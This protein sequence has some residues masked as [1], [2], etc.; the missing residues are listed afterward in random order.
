[1]GALGDEVVDAAPALGVA[2]VPV[3][4]RAVLDG[5]VVQRH[6]LDHR[7]VQLVLVAHRRGAALQV[8]DV[9]AFLGD[10][11]RALELAGAL[12]VDAEIG[13]QLHRAA[14]ALRDVDEGAVGEDRAVQR[15]EEV[16]A[17]RHHRAEVLRTSSGWFCTASE[18][19]Q[20]MMPSLASRSLKVV[21]TETLSNTASTAIGRRPLSTALRRRPR[22][23]PGWPAPSAGCRASRRCCSSSGSTSSS[24][25]GAGSGRRGVVVG[26]LVVDR[27]VVDGGPARLLHLQPHGDRP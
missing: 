4:H 12:R 21:A 23:R 16:V 25:F 15:R 17:L 11:Q 7:G 1:M 22:R 14:H 3:L 10:D 24:A 26:V 19:E 9:A 20:K 13:G 8:G 27:R 18:M 5:G 6:Q 2:G